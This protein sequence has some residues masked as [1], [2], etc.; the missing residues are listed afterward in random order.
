MIAKPA[1]AAIA[2]SDPIYAAIEKHQDARIPWDA[3]VDLRAAFPDT[4]AVRTEQWEELG[5]L[6]DAEEA[7]RVPLEQ[8]GADLINT[9][10]TT[11]PGIVG[12][13]H[14]LREQMKDDG[15]YMPQTF[16]LDT[17]GDAQNTM[18]WIDAWLDTI[19]A[20]AAALDGA[21]KAVQS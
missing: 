17:G 10:P 18:G 3:A 20:A 2:A 16:V 19:A 9:L 13:I 7:T 12:S 1:T 8:A 14:Y 4:A 21:G 6:D 5:R 11:L 15:T